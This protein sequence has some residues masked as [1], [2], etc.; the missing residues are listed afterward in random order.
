MNYS[1][2]ELTLD[3]TV[4]LSMMEQET[5]LFQPI[6]C[7]I[8]GSIKMSYTILD[9]IVY[10]LFILKWLFSIQANILIYLYVTLY[11]FEFGYFRYPFSYITL[12]WFDAAYN[13]SILVLRFLPRIN[14]QFGDRTR[15]C[16]VTIT[17]CKWS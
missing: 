10:K 3:N 1:L 13:L 16:F 2:S 17:D 11:K 9:L 14:G 4:T 12:I 5:F 7:F 8:R 6:T 15:W